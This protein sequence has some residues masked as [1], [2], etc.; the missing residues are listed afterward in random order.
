MKKECEFSNCYIISPIGKAGKADSIQIRNTKTVPP[1]MDAK[2]ID[3][4]NSGKHIL[5]FEIPRGYDGDIGPTGPEFATA[6]AY[7]YSDVGTVLNLTKQTSEKIPF[8]RSGNSKQV[9][10]SKD[11]EFIILVEGIYKIEYYYSGSITDD[12]A[13]FTE[14]LKN[15]E[16]IDGTTISKDVTTNVDNDFFASCIISLTKDD[17]IS[18]AVRAN[19]DTVLTSAPDT[20]AYIVITR[21]S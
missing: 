17:V 12:T 21:L 7:K 8:N 14:I 1:D 6:F 16:V 15:G 19:A 4:Y 18:L 20:N 11:D 3:T 13:F 5:D 2:V 10:I 9:D